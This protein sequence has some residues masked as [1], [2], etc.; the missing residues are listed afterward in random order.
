VVG[1]EVLQHLLEVELVDPMAADW[2]EAVV[3]V[4]LL[5]RRER[6][7]PGGGFFDPSAMA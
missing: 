2:A 3:L 1:I 5:E 7:F 6:Y 4:T